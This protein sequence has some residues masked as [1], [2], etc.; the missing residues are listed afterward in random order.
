MVTVRR[1]T[2]ADTPAIATMHEASAREL[3]RTHYDERQVRA[4][5]GGKRPDRY[6][7]EEPGEHVVVAEVDGELAGYGHLVVDD[8]EVRAVYVSPGQAR[9]GV[10]SALLA[11]LESTARDAG[12]EECY[13]W[14]SLNAVPF[15]RQA[16]WDVVGDEVV[17]TSGNGV[18]A[19]L[20]VKLMAKELG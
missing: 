17:E 18:T 14:A 12:H 11:H 5:S 16:G 3:G 15:Y 13:L 8:G 6:P 1:A 10:G 4:W 2:P 19:E 7:V 20:P 9:R